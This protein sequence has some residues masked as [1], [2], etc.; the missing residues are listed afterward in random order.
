M[1]YPCGGYRY[2]QQ[3]SFH[4]VLRSPSLEES[5]SCRRPSLSQPPITHPAAA[6]WWRPYSRHSPDREPP[7][8]VPWHLAS[9]QFGSHLPTQANRTGTTEPDVGADRDLASRV[10]PCE[11]AIDRTGEHPGEKSSRHR[12]AAAAVVATCG[13]PRAA[14]E[15]GRVMKVGLDLHGRGQVRARVAVDG[16]R[17]TGAAP[18]PIAATRDLGNTHGSRECDR[19]GSTPGCGAD[20]ARAATGLSTVA[21]TAAVRGSAWNVSDIGPPVATGSA[22]RPPEVVRKP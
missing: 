22:A 3:V 20:C 21:T 7:V 4:A 19:G 15:P 14:Q 16:Q 17:E 2:C 9:G 8:G 6:A 18:C 1:P 12:V 13:D 10:H 11:L 5:A